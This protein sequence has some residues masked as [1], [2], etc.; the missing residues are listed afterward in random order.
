MTLLRR[1]G[2]QK[3][4]WTFAWSSVATIFMTYGAM[5]RLGL[6][7]SD[8]PRVQFLCTTGEYRTLLEPG[9]IPDNPYLPPHMRL[10]MPSY[11]DRPDIQIA[12]PPEYDLTLSQRDMTLALQDILPVEDKREYEYGI[13]PFRF[14]GM[15][16]NIETEERFIKRR[17]GMTEDQKKRAPKEEYEM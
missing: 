6:S 11:L 13:G 4:F 17:L 9:A 2:S 15:M 16:S 10:D 5:R 1:A 14:R 3:Y 7:G 8:Y 12:T